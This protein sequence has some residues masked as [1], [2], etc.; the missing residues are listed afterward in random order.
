MR[1]KATYAHVSCPLTNPMAGN[2]PHNEGRTPH[3][4]LLPFQNKKRA[5]LRAGLF[6]IFKDFLNLVY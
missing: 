2:T 4:R 6:F 3:L 1:A 5:R